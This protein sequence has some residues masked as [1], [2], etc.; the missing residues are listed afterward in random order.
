MTTNAVR[1]IPFFLNF[2]VSESVVLFGIFLNACVFLVLDVNP[3]IGVEYPL[4]YQI[5]II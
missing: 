5:D 4:L 1:K 3:Q 2:A